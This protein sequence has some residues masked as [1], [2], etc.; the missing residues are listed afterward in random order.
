MHLG[1]AFPG[2]AGEL[3]EVDVGAK[4]G[5]AGGLQHGV[6]VVADDRLQGVAGP[7]F[8]A[9]IVDDQGAAAALAT[10]GQQALSQVAG[11]VDRGRRDLG[12][13]AQRRPLHGLR[14][15]GLGRRGLGGAHEAQPAVRSQ[16]DQAF[17]PALDGALE[18]ADGQGVEKL[19]GHHD[20]RPRRHLVEV[21]V[22]AH[23]V[24]RQRSPLKSA[25]HRAG[26]HQMQARRGEEG[27]HQASG[28][29]RV[30]HQGTA[31]GADLDQV[32]LG[33]RAHLPP[34]LGAP[35]PDQLAEHLRHLRCRDEVAL[36]SEGIAGHVI[37]PAR[38]AQ[39]L[40]HVAV[41]A[42]GAFA[43]D[44]VGEVA[45][46]PG[47]FSCF[48]HGRSGPGQRAAPAATATGPWW[49]PAPANP[50]GRR[51]GGRTRP[52]SGPGRSPRERRR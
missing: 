24:V 34:Q 11:K 43:G 48:G 28:P 52:G 26:F 29:Q 25:Q 21:L 35:Q 36:Q 18:L 51:V 39:R 14:D 4:I 7:A 46:Q 40:G 37:A 27:R 33:R 30:G 22:P 13:A 45:A 16:A 1:A 41:D 19:V 8:V 50:D 15:Q 9:A 20:G 42:D 10:W 6:A 17:A 31:A 44:Q 12:H 47:R 5:A 38:I 23:L 3:G 2:R 49:R 32:E